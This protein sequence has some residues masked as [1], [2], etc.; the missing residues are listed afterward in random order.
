MLC[1]TINVIFSVRQHYTLLFELM[2]FNT[3][4]WQ[5]HSSCKSSLFT[6]W[7]AHYKLP[8]IDMYDNFFKFEGKLAAYER[9]SVFCVLPTG[10]IVINGKQ[11]VVIF[12]FLARIVSFKLNLTPTRIGRASCQ[13]RLT[14]E[15]DDVLFSCCT[16]IYLFKTVFR[17]QAISYVCTFLSRLNHIWEIFE[18]PEERNTVT[19][20]RDK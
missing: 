4:L 7:V 17:N 14:R 16:V 20:T 12:L 5:F 13:F 18:W 15:S 11:S 9:T 19:N 6:M 8:G 1:K 3:I 10:N 2:Q